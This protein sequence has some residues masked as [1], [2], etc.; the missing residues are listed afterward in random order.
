MTC[1]NR[2]CHF[3]SKNKTPGLGQQS[4]C[5][6][7]EANRCIKQIFKDTKTTAA[8]INRNQVKRLSNKNNL[9]DNFLQHLHLLFELSSKQI[10]QQPG[11]SSQN[12]F[13]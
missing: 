11:S 8:V 6:M 9:P 4:C 3:P 7:I 5:F 1:F 12:S 2:L 10:Q 13:H